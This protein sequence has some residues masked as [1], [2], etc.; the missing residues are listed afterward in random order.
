MLEVPRR[1][2]PRQE[3]EYLRP[4]EVRAVLAAVSDKYRPL[5]ACAIY[6]D[7]RKGELLGL[8]KRDIDWQ[9]LQISVRRSH[10][11]ETTKGGCEGVVPMAAELVPF[12]QA[13]AAAAPGQH[14]FP[15]GGGRHV[16]CRAA[17]AMGRQSR[18]FSA[19]GSTIPRHPNC[20]LPAPTFMV[21]AVSV[22]GIAH[23]SWAPS[24][25]KRPNR[26]LHMLHRA[27]IPPDKLCGA[28][29]P[30]PVAS[31]GSQAAALAL[32]APVQTLRPSLSCARQSAPGR[33][34]A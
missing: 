33:L 29:W 20:D 18:S 31:E 10:D 26:Q 4:Q 24:C 13:A 17:S 22:C 8:H 34:E 1:R 9:A 5:F 2:V 16:Q 28:P 25:A 21:L 27:P 11:R 32:L 19:T 12:L 7:L 15:G 23:D 3:P 6:A 14:L 30:A